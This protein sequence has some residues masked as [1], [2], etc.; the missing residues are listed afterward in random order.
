MKYAVIKIGSKQYQVEEGKTVLVDLQKTKT[1]DE[2]TFSEVVLYVDGETIKIGTPVLNGARVV[3]QT[4]EIVKD[5]KVV[6]GK[7][8]R[9]EGYRR[10]YGH[11]NKYTPVKITQIIIG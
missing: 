4:G 2:I 3:G 9:R 11:R 1:G 10:S 5:K 7:F 8:R 6:T